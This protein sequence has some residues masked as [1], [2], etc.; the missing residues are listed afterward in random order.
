MNKL[1]K[2]TA[3]LLL[4]MST[5]AFFGCD[6]DTPLVY[7][8]NDAAKYGKITVTLEGTRPDGEDFTEKKEFRFLPE[9]S[10]VYSSVGFDGDAYFYVQ[11]Q[12]GAVTNSHNDNYAAFNFQANGD[13]PTGGY[14]YLYTSVIDDDDNVVFYLDED[15]TINLDDI[16]SFSYDEE[17]GKVRLKFI[18]ELDAANNNT[19][20]DLTITVDA[21][22]T[23]FRQLNQNGGE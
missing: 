11:R 14:F 3:G 7:G 18:T 17:S 6:D 22:V 19:G 21:G 15:F 9:E 10:V 1:M 2:S 23:V 8:L 4:A 5:A 20:F 13:T 16:T 12:H